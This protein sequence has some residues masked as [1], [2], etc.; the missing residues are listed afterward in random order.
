MAYQLKLFERCSPELLRSGGV[1]CPVEPCSADAGGVR[2][3]HHDDHA[4][5]SVSGTGLAI[6]SAAQRLLAVSAVPAAAVDHAE[7]VATDISRSAPDD[8]LLRQVIAQLIRRIPRWN[9][10][11]VP[12]AR[13]GHDWRLL[14]EDAARELPMT[15]SPAHLDMK[16]A[17]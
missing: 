13:P 15:A 8:P 1:K 7:S 17:R 12:S 11:P 2:G 10:L 6:W 9:Y 5:I 16:G 3:D 14:L 4:R